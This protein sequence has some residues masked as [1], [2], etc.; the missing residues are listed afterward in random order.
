MRFPCLPA[1]RA[2][3]LEPA[4]LSRIARG[5]VV[6]TPSKF[7]PRDGASAGEALRAASADRGAI[8]SLSLRRG[9]EF[10]HACL[11]E[12]DIRERVGIA[13]QFAADVLDRKISELPAPSSRRARAA[14]SGRRFSLC[15]GPASGGRAARN[16]CECAAREC[17]GSSRNRARRAARSIRRR[18][19]FRGR[20]FF[21]SSRT[22]F[23]VRI[24]HDDR[25]GSRAGIAARCSVN[26]RDVNAC[27][28]R[29]GMRF[30]KKTR[31]RQAAE[32]LKTVSSRGRRSE[33]VAGDRDSDANFHRSRRQTQRRRK[34]RLDRRAGTPLS[35]RCS[36]ECECRSRSETTPR[37]SRCR[38]F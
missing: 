19:S 22:D 17:R 9:C 10:R 34:L 33:R 31:A 16:R 11:I 7:E 18:C 32:F 5:S 14:A 1:N 23:S 27:R 25:V 13:I 36:R 3:R 6:V 30:G 4:H 20:Y 29:G 21:A 38:I 26:I 15:S 12:R 24:A 35:A 8:C 2:A 28:R 37:C